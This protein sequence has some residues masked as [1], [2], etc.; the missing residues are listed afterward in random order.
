M[1]YLLNTYQHG[2][3]LDLYRN[4]HIH[5]TKWWF[6]SCNTCPWCWPLTFDTTKILQAPHKGQGKCNTCQYEQQHGT[7]HDLCMNAHIRPFGETSEN[8]PLDMRS[9]YCWLLCD[10][11]SLIFTTKDA[12]IPVEPQN[13]IWRPGEVQYLIQLITAWHYSWPAY[14]HPFL[15]IQPSSI[16]KSNLLRSRKWL[17]KMDLLLPT[18]QQVNPLLTIS[19]RN[20]GAE[21]Q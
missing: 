15:V 1:Q 8:L 3:A 5:Y 13:A 21:Q 16:L 10:V 18:W 14:K 17:G 6:S 2:T 11:W 4:T 19:A 7:T 9:Y 20:I 12:C